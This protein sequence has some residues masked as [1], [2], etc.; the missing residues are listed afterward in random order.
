[1]Q[2]TEGRKSAFVKHHAAEAFNFQLTMALLAVANVVVAISLT[3]ATMGAWII[4]VVPIHL[5]I[6][7]SVIGFSIVAATAAHR[8]EWYQ[9]PVSLR[10][11]PGARPQP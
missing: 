9:Y 4:A 6:A 3:P 1:M 10:V 2:Q 11:L 5:G 8:G 7:S